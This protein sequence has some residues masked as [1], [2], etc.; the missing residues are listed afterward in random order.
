MKPVK[1]S[2]FTMIEMMIVL[3]IIGILAAIAYPSYQ[4]QVRDSRRSDCAGELELLSNAM[5]RRFT[6]NASYAGGL[7]A[8][9]NT[10]PIN[11]GSPMY[12]FA[13]PA[14]TAT[15]FT[16]SAAPIGPQAGERC[17]TLTLTNTG[18]KGLNGAAA[19]LTVQDCW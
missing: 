6:L 8:G 11:G 1:H 7:P 19:G 12:Q 13:I 10:C 4:Q 3:A 5:E 16:V 17:G 9:F 15:T 14:S 18:V 2:G